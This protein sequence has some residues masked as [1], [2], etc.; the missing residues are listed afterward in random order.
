MS[1][2]E[3]GLV[4]GIISS[5]VAIREACDTIWDAAQHAR[6]LPA[7][8]RTSAEQ[9][10]L[11]IHILNLAG[12]NIKAK[13]VDEESRKAALPVLKQCQENAQLV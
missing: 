7:K 12:Q 11:V 8:L 4:L 3:V 6:G 5:T 9:I 1:G 2:A 13:Q 10:P